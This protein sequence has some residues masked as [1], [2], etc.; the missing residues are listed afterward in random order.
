MTLPNLPEISAK[1]ESSTPQSEPAVTVSPPAAVTS[2]PH[3]FA[4]LF[5]AYAKSYL[6][7]LTTY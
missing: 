2:W 7:R 6:A 1:L 5:S 3:L 4:Q